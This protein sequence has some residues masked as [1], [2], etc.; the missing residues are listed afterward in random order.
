MTN[1][2]NILGIDIGAHKVA[3]VLYDDKIVASHHEPYPEEVK[4]NFKTWFAW[5]QESIKDFLEENKLTPDAIGVGVAGII[6]EGKITKSS[7]LPILE[8]QDIKSLLA[9]TFK[10]DVRLENDVNCFLRTETSLGAAQSYKNVIVLTL[11]TGIGGGILINN[12]MYF[13]STASAGEIG[14]M[15]IDGEQT[16]EDLVSTRGFKRLGGKDSKVLAPMAREGDKKA[17]EIFNKVGKYLGRG[18]ANLVN[19]LDPEVI[20]LGGGISLSF[21]LMENSAR[22]EMKKTIFSPESKKVK[23]FVSEFKDHAVALGAALLF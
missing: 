21:D 11:G 8:G 4:K 18:L 6:Q 5:L 2:K 13:G 20:I 3:L 9:E 10:V 16:L 1:Y 7:N 12:E 17:Q 19:I 14:H 23:L 22:E 15:I